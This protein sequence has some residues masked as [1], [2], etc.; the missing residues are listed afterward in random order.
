MMQQSS[1]IAIFCCYAR[2]DTELLKELKSHLSP[3]ERRKVI[4]VW[5][6]GKISAGTEWDQEIKK[7]LNNAQIILL[8]ISSDFIA[9]DYGYNTELKRAME[10]HE[11]KEA[12]VIPVILRP[13]SE[14]EEVSSGDIHLGKLQALPEE[15]NPV[16]LWTNRDKAWKNVVDGIKQ[17]VI[18]SWGD[19]GIRWT[20]E[21][22]TDPDPV[23]QESIQTS[24]QVQSRRFVITAVA[25]TTIAAGGA[26]LT[27]ASLIW[28]GTSNHT[29]DT[30]F[31]YS[32]H[33]GSV[34]CVAWAPDATRL[35]SGSND[36]QVYVYG[37][38]GLDQYRHTDHA[39]TVTAL[40]WSPSGYWIASASADMTV[41]V[42]ISARPADQLTRPEAYSYVYRGHSSPVRAVAWSPD[43]Q[44]IA[45][46]GED[47]KV[48]VW[49][50]GI[51]KKDLSRSEAGKDSNLILEGHSDSVN[52]IAW[53]P[54]GKYL[55]SGS[56]DNTVK[57]WDVSRLGNTS[58]TPNVSGKPVHTF[59]Q[60]SHVLALAWSP[61]SQY[62][63]C[64]GFD[65]AIQVWSQEKQLQLL[66]YRGHDSSVWSVTWSLD[67]QYIASASEDQ[68]VRVWDL[69]GQTICVYKEH[70]GRVNSVSWAPMRGD[71]RIASA[72]D[73]KK[74]RVWQLL[75]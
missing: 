10:R 44:Y 36:R 63:A 73:D 57:I 66:S 16:T 5:Y 67:S 29:Y 43:G 74:V 47:Q 64:G 68:T 17:V 59:G 19:E 32:R 50:S 71:K 2:E 30:I 39:R 3:L 25:A 54:D 60:P 42:W 27:G 9:S 41:H 37:S 70:S 23:A 75:V 55:A 58:Q 45:S 48:R 52:A 18:E 12:R 53:S 13:V 40:A 28:W 34:F 38:T 26:A 56:G 7:H 72:G 20:Q 24:K 49:Q 22:P 61:D 4:D 8:L 31:T 35:A 69:T 46:G 62:L 15:A 51:V 14:W 33:I 1:A 11:R 6:D 21:R 65:R